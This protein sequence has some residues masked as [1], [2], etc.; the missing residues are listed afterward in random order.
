M[1][2]H[3]S[4]VTSDSPLFDADGVLLHRHPDLWF[5]DGSVVCRAENTLFF[6]H[7]SQLARHS[8]CFRDMFSIGTHSTGTEAS[9]KS[10]SGVD[11]FPDY[12]VITLHDSAEDVGNLFTALYDGPNFGNND[13]LDF[14]VVSGVLRLSTKYIIDGLR[15]KAIVHL[16]QAWP[17]TLKGWDTREDTARSFEMKTG[18]S[19]GHMYPSPIAVI[20][21]AR[22][23]DAPTLLPSAFYDL[24]RYTYSQIFEP[25]EDD[26]LYVPLTYSN[27]SPA[28]SPGPHSGPMQL[29]LSDTQRLCLGK[30]S[31]LHAITGLIQSMSH[32]QS[33]RNSGVQLQSAFSFSHPLAQNPAH[34]AIIPHASNHHNPYHI[35]FSNHRRSS[36]N[37]ICVSAAAC[38]KDFSEL[39]ELATQHYVF[40]RE[41]GFSDPL[42]VADELGQLKSAEFSNSD[43]PE[44]KACARSLELWAAR[45]RERIWRMVPVWFRL[46]MDVGAERTASPPV[47]DIN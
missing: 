46:S 28:A 29:S 9:I 1:H 19:S 34:S 18:S 6:V 30:E 8:V 35:H 14:R 13:P 12:P 42:Y 11:E 16:S 10:E 23:V 22:E 25:S 44:C 5:E 3:T 24:C 45:E 32:S 2:T 31:A 43:A 15:E 36:S 39:V 4:T 37:L 38:R 27:A 33:I 21:L 17:T 26:P 41:R 7:M 20:N 40:D 47:V